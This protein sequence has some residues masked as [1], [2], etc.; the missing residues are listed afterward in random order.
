ME[1]ITSIRLGVGITFPSP[2]S[3]KT[4]QHQRASSQVHVEMPDPRLFDFDQNGQVDAN[5]VIQEKNARAERVRL[6]AQADKNL[7][8]AVEKSASVEDA[9][10][11]PA[12]DSALS[13]LA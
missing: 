12:A 10:E 2:L 4:K 8:T 5:D 11:K 6:S 7:S 1:T 3:H 13:V 9:Q